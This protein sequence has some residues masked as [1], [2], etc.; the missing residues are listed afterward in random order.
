MSQAALRQAP[1][2]ASPFQINPDLDVPALAEAYA[3]DGRVRIY[4]L[5]SE[6]AAYL[7]D[8]L[9]TNPHWI[10]LIKLEKG[11][12]ELDAEKRAALSPRNGRRSK[13]RPTNVP[14][15]TFNI[16]TTVCASPTA[17]SWTRPRSARRSPSSPN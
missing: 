4:G 13:L 2:A 3:R 8:Y 1:A 12:L 16:A 17:R 6:G 15:T 5:L 9:D 14:A 11:A 10:K 7:H